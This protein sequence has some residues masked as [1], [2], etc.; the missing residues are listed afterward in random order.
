MTRSC[1]HAPTRLF[2]TDLPPD[3]RAESRIALYEHGYHML[4]RDLD[5]A[6]VIDDV[7]RLGRRPPRRPPVRRRPAGGRGPALP[8]MIRRASLDYSPS[9]RSG[10]VL[11][12]RKGLASS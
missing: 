7:E 2:I 5:A 11:G 8:G 12:M 4:L 10:C 3:E 6:I 1:P 9:R